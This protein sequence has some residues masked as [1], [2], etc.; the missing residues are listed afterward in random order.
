MKIQD[1]IQ[2]QNQKLCLFRQNES[3]FNKQ[4]THERRS[5]TE[6]EKLQQK[7]KPMTILAQIL[8]IMI[9]MN[10]YLLCVLMSLA[11]KFQINKR[12]A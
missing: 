6:K 1:T 3:S 4:I 9:P 5:E 2:V 10:S 11:L 7:E 8:A 12:D